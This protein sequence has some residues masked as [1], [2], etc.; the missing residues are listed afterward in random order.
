MRSSG[1]HQRSILFP[2]GNAGYSAISIGNLLAWR[3]I[4]LALLAASMQI[5]FLIE[6]PEGSALS[7]HR[8]FGRLCDLV[9]DRCLKLLSEFVP[10][11]V[12]LLW[13]CLMAGIQNLDL[14]RLVQVLPEHSQASA[15]LGK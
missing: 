7:V 15:P 1:T 12:V 6:Q 5:R 8:A 9:E 2:D 10:V 14:A 11:G 3:T 4:A 13:S